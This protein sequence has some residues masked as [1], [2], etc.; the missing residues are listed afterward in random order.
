MLNQDNKHT[1][2]EGR[3]S[4]ALGITGCMKCHLLLLRFECTP[5]SHP[6]LTLFCRSGLAPAPRSS[7]TTLWWPLKLA[8]FN[9]VKPSCMVKW[10]IVTT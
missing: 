5:L 8:C 6:V 3:L 2:I 9:A 10:M 7:S 1:S 4:R